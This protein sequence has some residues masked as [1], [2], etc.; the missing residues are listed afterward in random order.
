MATP[1]CETAGAT[2]LT[3]ANLSGATLAHADFTGACMI[4]ADLSSA[5]GEQA[6]FD[7]A[8]LAGANMTTGHFEAAS[9]ARA[10]VNGASLRGADIRNAD[11]R[12]LMANG[13]YAA[14]GGP[15][16]FANFMGAHLYWANTCGF[17]MPP[18]INQ[19]DLGGA[20]HDSRANRRAW[21][22]GFGITY[23]PTALCHAL[24][25]QT[26]TKFDASGS[27]GELVLENGAA[28]ANI[29]F[30]DKATSGP[31][32]TLYPSIVTLLKNGVLI[33]IGREGADDYDCDYTKWRTLN[34]RGCYDLFA[35]K[36]GTSYVLF[37]P[38][39]REATFPTTITLQAIGKP[40]PVTQNPKPV[41]D[42]YAYQEGDMAALNNKVMLGTL[43]L[44]FLP[45]GR[46]ADAA[47]SSLS[48]GPTIY[49]RA[50]SAMSRS[51]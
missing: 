13:L 31:F 10:N 47:F 8:V 17:Q 35:M 12:F 39:P 16:V 22:N 41:A 43:L 42:F 33:P 4:G 15:A 34:T 14:N 23:V 50:F 9:F 30:A 45:G 5:I 29:P 40:F 46:S 24:P 6:I 3:S 36:M 28:I 7:R 25:T 20:L 27:Q 19:A 21:N 26:P 18:S 32:V 44:N 49:R 2:S 11:L 38:T 37:R 1:P 48:G 51:T